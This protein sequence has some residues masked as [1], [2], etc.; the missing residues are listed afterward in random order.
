M[1][2]VITEFVENMLN[3]L[4]YDKTG[5]IYPLLTA[6]SLFVVSPKIFASRKFANVSK[7]AQS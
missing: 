7:T 3:A 5:Y 6:A 2:T 1:A 4:A